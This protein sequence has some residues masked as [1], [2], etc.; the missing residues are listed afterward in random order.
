MAAL[1]RRVSGDLRDQANL[2]AVAALAGP[3][4]VRGDREVMRRV[5]LLALGAAVEALLGGRCLVAAAA[6]ARLA[7]CTRARRV[8]VVAADTGAHHTVLR[9]IGVL[10]LVTVRAGGFG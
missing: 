1:A 7:L 6:A 10:V 5:A 8:R 3:P 2:L 9:V 4:V